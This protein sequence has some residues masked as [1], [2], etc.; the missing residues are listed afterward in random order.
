MGTAY[1]RRSAVGGCSKPRV[2]KSSRKTSMEPSLGTTTGTQ[3]GSAGA[4]EVEVGKRTRVVGT[5]TVAGWSDKGFQDS[6]RRSKFEKSQIISE[7][8][9]KPDGCPL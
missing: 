3:I 5:T 4:K 8:V 7:K 6:H 2:M 9:E 1:A